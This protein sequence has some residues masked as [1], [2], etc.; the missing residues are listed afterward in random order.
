[1]EKQSAVYA[2]R[3]VGNSNRGD[4]SAIEPFLAGVKGIDAGI[5]R[6]LVDCLKLSDQQ[7]HGRLQKR[8]W[9]TLRRK[10]RGVSSCSRNC[11]SEQK[12]SSGHFTFCCVWA[13]NSPVLSASKNYDFV[14]LFPL[15]LMGGHNVDTKR[16]VN[17]CGEMHL[18]QFVL[19]R[20]NCTCISAGRAPFFPESRT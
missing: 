19:Y 9:I 7:F 2:C 17:G 5:R 12:F 14:K 11:N 16:L 18:Q 10:N 13:N 15:G 20:R 8:R 3:Y 1:M 6:Q 4:N